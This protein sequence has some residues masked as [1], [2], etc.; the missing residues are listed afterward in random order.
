[1][2][3]IAVIYLAFCLSEFM[4][5]RFYSFSQGLESRIQNRRVRYA[6]NSLLTTDKLTKQTD[7]PFARQLSPEGAYG[8]FILDSDSWLLDSLN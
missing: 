7:V 8:L 4:T 5:N 1:M 2:M 6:C 3:L